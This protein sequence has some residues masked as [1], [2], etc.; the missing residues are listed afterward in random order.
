MFSKLLSELRE[1]IYRFAIPHSEWRSE[2]VENP[3]PYFAECIG[4]PSG[5]YFP[6]SGVPL[7]RINKQ[8]RQEALPLAYRK[9]LFSFGDIDDLIKLLIAIGNIGRDNIESLGFAWQSR[10]DLECQGAEALIATEP[11]LS[12]PALH[13]EKCV[14]LLKQCKNLKFLSLSFNSDVIRHMSPDAYKMDTGICDLRSIQVLE[15]VEI[16]DL[17]QEPLMQ[18]EFIR[19]LKEAMERSTGI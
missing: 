13:V 1:K 19:W 8:I 15:R 2:D 16:Y 18:C 4:D 14:I 7:L 17:F 11:M 10:I 6:L 9:T 12:L 5:F 3:M